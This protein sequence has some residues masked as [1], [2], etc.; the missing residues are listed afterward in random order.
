VLVTCGAVCALFIIHAA[1]LGPGDH[2]LVETPNY[3]TNLETPKAMA[4]A[5]V[6]MTQWRLHAA[7]GYRLDVPAFCAEITKETKL[8][9]VTSPHNPTGAILREP[10]LRAIIA[11]VKERG[12]PD[13]RLLVD[14]TYREMVVP[15]AAESAS[16]DAGGP[17]A[18]TLAEAARG[19]VG[20]AA[21]SAALGALPTLT[22]WAATLDPCVISVSSMS[23]TWGLPGLRIGWITTLDAG[24]QYTLL[25]AKEQIA[26][27]GS[28]IDEEIAAH[29]LSRRA[30]LLPAVLADIAVRK[31]TVLDW[32]AANADV[33]ECTPPEGGVV[34][35]PHIRSPLVD[36]ASF[37]DRLFA[38]S[39][40]IVGAGHWFEVSDRHFRLGFGWPTHEQL[41]AGLESIARVLRTMAAEAARTA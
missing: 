16:V 20:A 30:E 37:N 26:I 33:I 3:A 8:V 1:L 5:G 6:R 36:A 2:L 27:S 22:P 35:F 38:D 19:D 13:C 23:K 15:A 34:C 9:S 21:T 29:V 18:G 32:L 14:E 11:A 40:T 17:G 7:A 4:D 31:Q 41:A 39:S 12:H 25:A 28:V 10:E 24:L